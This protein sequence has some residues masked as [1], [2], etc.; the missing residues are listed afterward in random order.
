MT[1]KKSEDKTGAGSGGDRPLPVFDH[2]G[3]G[4]PDE[5]DHGPERPGS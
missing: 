4:G 3:S 2:S 5:C 1:K